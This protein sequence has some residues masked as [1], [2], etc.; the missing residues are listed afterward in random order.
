MNVDEGAAGGTS[1]DASQSG[2]GA[3]EEKVERLMALG[4][5]RQ[6]CLAALQA[7]QGNEDAA[8]AILFG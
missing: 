8:A 1:S 5:S 4:F 2:A 6:A 3:L 7:A